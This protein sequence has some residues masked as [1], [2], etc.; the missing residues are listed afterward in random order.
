MANE[1]QCFNLVKSKRKTFKTI[2]GNFK[3]SLL[4]EHSR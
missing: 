1:L 2:K 4:G 3:F